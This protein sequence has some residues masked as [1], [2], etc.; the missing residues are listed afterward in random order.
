MVMPKIEFK[1]GTK[2][3]LPT[4]DVGEPAF[5]TDTKEFFI[6]SDE[7]NIEFAKQ[8][9]LDYT[10]ANVANKAEQ[11]AL[12]ATNA[13]VTNNTNTLNN[14]PNVNANAEVLSARGTFPLL[15]NRLDNVDASLAK[16]TNYAK[17]NAINVKV[18][19]VGNLTGAKGDGVTDD[20]AALQAI[21]NYATANKIGAVYLP[22]G[23]Y[24]ITNTIHLSTTMDGITIFGDSRNL[25]II[26][27][28]ADVT[29]IDFQQS[30]IV[31]DIYIRD[32]K[33]IGVLNAVNA[34]P[35]INLKSSSTYQ[36]SSK[37]Y[38]ENVDIRQGYDGIA[39]D[40]IIMS[41]FKNVN[42]SSCKNDGFVGTTFVTSTIFQNCY[43]NA[44][45]RYGYNTPASYVTF[46]NCACDNAGSD[47]Y[48]II[49]LGGGNV[50]FISCDAEFLSGYAIY[51][52]TADYVTVIG[53]NITN[54]PGNFPAMY[55]NNTSIV[56]IS[57]LK[58]NYN[59]PTTVSPITLAGNSNN[60]NIVNGYI[61]RQGGTNPLV[62][63]MTKAIFTNYGGV[64]GIGIGINPNFPLH[65]F[66]TNY[67]KACFGYPGLANW[68]VKLNSSGYFGIA[69]NTTDNG[70]LFIKTNSMD[71][72]LVITST[73]IQIGGDSYHN[74][75]IQAIN[76]NSTTWA[77]GTIASNAIV[78]TTIGVDGAAIGDQ[79]ALGFSNAL[80]AG[81]ILVGNVTANNGTTGTVTVTLLNMTGASQ[82]IASG[83]LKATV[84]KS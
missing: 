84:I 44:V 13:Q 59:S 69:K 10:N 31:R 52:D 61:N 40:S 74:A 58:I 11:T 2:D 7:G 81:L 22:S 6:G 50:S 1:R 3:K 79:V 8:S 63:D 28:N 39:F 34:V 56:N 32:L 18:P 17:W 43:A 46:Q 27:N 51:V 26:Q 41:S 25:T 48:H 21:F 49:G 82:T 78:S 57:N 71:K 16:N 15:G 45:G 80:P 20:T 42:V 14:L 60:I 29:S 65:M 33:I 38:I 73:G 12:D 4:L 37:C 47:A 54:I 24:I 68:Y 66:E 83:T 23:T 72:A 53:S 36:Y 70:S 9:D 75:T 67:V 76:G 55:L 5:T 62:S 30:G 64:V 77:P 19:F 35:A